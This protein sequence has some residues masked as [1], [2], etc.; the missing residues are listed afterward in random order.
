MA[1][2][3]IAKIIAR[4]GICSRR[5]AER[6]ITEGRVTYKGEVIETPALKFTS[7]KGIKVD[8]Y[9][10][11]KPQSKLWLYH[12]PFGLIV[13]HQDDQGRETI[14]DNLP[15]NERVI[16]VGRL[17]KNTSGLLLLTNDGELARKLE[18]PENNFKRVYMVRVFG[19]LNF[20]LIKKELSKPITIDGVTY[21]PVKIE[22][23][24][25]GPQNH[26]LR[27]TITE[28][29]N[30]EIRN[31]LNHFDLRINKLIRIQYGPFE[32]LDLKLE[33]VYEVTDWKKVLKNRLS[34]TD[35]S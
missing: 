11:E 5:E 29:K 21:R 19:Q 20:P 15:I 12:K 32:L 17:D 23:E 33:H 31:I 18:L 26:W 28:G 2:E 35:F 16:S 3:R 8:G 14:F 9:S 1:E 7:M 13:S 10:L 27:L 6:L 4:A 22:L 30:R 25:K 34:R 24:H